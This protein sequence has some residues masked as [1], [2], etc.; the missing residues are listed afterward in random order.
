MP[1]DI[2]WLIETPRLRMRCWTPDDVA[3]FRP[4]AQDPRVMRYIHTGETW[5][6]PRIEAFVH[7]QLDLKREHGFS[8]C[9]LIHRE[10]NAFIGFCGLQPLGDTGEIEIGWWLAVAYWDQGLATEAARAV[11]AHGFTELGLS[12][13]VAI[14]QPPNTASINVMRK[15]GMTYERTRDWRGIEVVQYA[16]KLE[17]SLQAASLNIRRSI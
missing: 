3:D 11:V 8:L 2:C 5:S 12:R 10:D 17:Y 16:I 1:D 9:P 14:A 13:I 15:L 6:D 7:R 4:I